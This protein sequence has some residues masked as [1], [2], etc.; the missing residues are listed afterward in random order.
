MNLP[1]F[2]KSP[3]KLSATDESAPI[4]I[5][6][7]GGAD[8]SALLSLLCRA[9]DEI[10]FKLYAAHV[11]HGIRTEQYSN[12]ALRDE[13][14]CRRLCESLGVE[15]FVKQTD[16][17]TLAKS[18]GRSLEAEAREARYGFFAEIMKQTGIRILATAHNA[19]DNL[20]TQ[21]FNLCRGC[22][23]SGI[24]GIPE[25]RRFDGVEGGII[26]R[27]ILSATKSEILSFCE[28]NGIEY[29]T[30]STNLEDDCT[31]NVIR[32]KVLPELR[33]LFGSP[34]KSSLRLSLAAREDD[35]FIA[36]EA[37]SFIL[38]QGD[39]IDVSSLLS[40]HIS[41][42]KRALRLAFEKVSDATLETVHVNDT[43]YFAQ[44][45][46]N[47]SISLPDGVSA[48]FREGKL[49]FE[50]ELGN[51]SSLDYEQVLCEG[52]NMIK[53][54]PFAVLISK[55]A[56]PQS[57]IT[58]GGEKYELYSSAT[59]YLDDVREISAS[60]RREGDL[61]VDNGMHKRLKKL[62]CDKKV[63]LRDREDLPVIKK[64][65]EIIYAPLCAVA[66]PV[67]S[68]EKSAN[69]TITIYKKTVSEEKS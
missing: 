15:L 33:S 19:T 23:I 60:N 27:P 34:E 18:S 49:S 59:L 21:I 4:L 24:C 37:K 8:S 65:N 36:N 62:M 58:L 13:K 5:A 67:R 17:P 47:G 54:T 41:V 64:S 11:N 22:G 69:Y 35:E 9:R 63:P 16:I 66:D 12:E 20:E 53:G 55:A 2:Y 39:T 61:I 56:D 1:N 43:L 44:T 48:V 51:K 25:A 30:D 50:R 38:G 68:Q 10:G 29:V 7:S 28:E 42:S 52:E 32:H 45:R 57:N 3:H 31:R 46:R 6:L 14:F 40:C 26:V